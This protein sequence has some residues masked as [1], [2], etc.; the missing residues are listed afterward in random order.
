MYKLKFVTLV[1]LT[2]FNFCVDGRP[3][4]VLINYRFEGETVAFEEVGKVSSVKTNSVSFIVLL[5]GAI[6]VFISCAI[7][8]ATLMS[9]F[10]STEFIRVSLMMITETMSYVSIYK[11]RC[12][13]IYSCKR[14]I[15]KCIIRHEKV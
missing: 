10:H 6:F 11:N 9:I 2:F 13:I 4:P 3:S 1:V 14:N 7:C 8:A 5:A 15:P 12:Q